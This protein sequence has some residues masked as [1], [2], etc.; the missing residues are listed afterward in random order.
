[1]NLTKNRGKKG[2]GKGY[3]T[4][5]K[6]IWYSHSKDD[7]SI[8]LKRVGYGNKNTPESKMEYVMA[9]IGVGGPVGTLSEFKAIFPQRELKIIN[10]D[11]D[12]RRE[13]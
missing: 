5:A 7:G 6:R 10:L 4:P 9:G 11:D 1:M 2:N 13:N 3:F 12:E 8:M